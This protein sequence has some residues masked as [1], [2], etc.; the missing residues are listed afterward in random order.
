MGFDHFAGLL[1]GALPDYYAWEKTTDGETALVERYATTETVDDAIR[2]L[3]ARDGPWLLWLAFV[4]PHTPF[5]R[6]PEGL[7]TGALSDDPAEIRANAR[8]YYDAAIEALDAELGRLI[9]HLDA[10]TLART[11]IVFVGDNGTPPR[12]VEAPYDRTRAKG[13]LFEGGVHVPLV[14]AGPAVVDGG[15]RTRALANGVDLFATLLDLA[16]RWEA[17]TPSDYD[18]RSLAPLLADPDAPAVREWAYS[19]RFGANVDASEGG[20]TAR[21]LRYKRVRFTDG[22]E[23]LYD[24]ALDPFETSSLLEGALDAEQQAAF[25]ALGAVLDAN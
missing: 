8:V 17:L 24:L 12:A 19:E 13:T 23:A 14:V 5:H 1:R 3:D 18:G 16:G 2:W 10:E 4:A 15:R 22:R 7:Y 21:D 6:P 25:D 20:R 9:A 11:H